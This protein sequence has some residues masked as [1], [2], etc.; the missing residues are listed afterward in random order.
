MA[1]AYF[2]VH[3]P[4]GL[5][6]MENSGE[7][8]A[9]FCWAFLLLVFTGSGARPGPAVRQALGGLEDPARQA[10]SGGGLTRPA[11]PDSPGT[12]AP[13]PLGTGAVLLRASG[14]LQDAA[15]A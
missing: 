10:V 4:N 11:L 8:A 12:T 3:Q 15:A 9:M 7:G 5:W 2:K 1:Y 6:P 14:L 13:V